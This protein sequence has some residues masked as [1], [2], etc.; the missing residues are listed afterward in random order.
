MPLKWS[1][2][3]LIASNAVSKSPLLS[4]CV[5]NSA[6]SV[7]AAP[8]A[9]VQLP[10]EVT[11]ESTW[12]LIN[13]NAVAIA[14]SSASASAES[15]SVSALSNSRLANATA[16]LILPEAVV[17][18][19]QAVSTPLSTRVAASA[20]SETAESTCVLIK[21]HIAWVSSNSV[22]IAVRAVVTSELWADANFSNSFDAAWNTTAFLKSQSSSPLKNLHNL[23]EQFLNH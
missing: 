2:A 21:S 23:L 7:L 15:A 18:A 22:L 10:S 4:V 3:V 13:P 1:T 12:V 16:V 20:N 5:A 19:A 9:V 14:P 8:I 17:I 11:A 6:A